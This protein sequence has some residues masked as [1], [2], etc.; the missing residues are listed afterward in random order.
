MIDWDRADR[1]R[2][3]IGADDF[4]DVVALFVQECDETIQTIRATGRA[5]PDVLHFLKGAAL[6]LGFAELAR[7]CAEGEGLCPTA[8]PP[9]PARIVA[10][11]AATRSAFLSRR[12]SG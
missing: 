1:L 5:G 2:D 11:Y 3:E 10:V 6:N 9:D 8:P 12:R 4:D 7:L